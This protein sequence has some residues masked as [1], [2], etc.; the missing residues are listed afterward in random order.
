M[1]HRR[2]RKR[3]RRTGDSW[4][5]D[6]TGLRV[7]APAPEAFDEADLLLVLQLRGGQREAPAALG[8]GT[9]HE[10]IEDANAGRGTCIHPA[11][12]VLSPWPDTPACPFHLRRRNR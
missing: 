6:L 1:G 12:G 8:C 5:N 3:E 9:C 2:N 7:V 10:F 11:S 4:G